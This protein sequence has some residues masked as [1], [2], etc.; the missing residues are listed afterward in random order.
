MTT[1]AVHEFTVELVVRRRLPA[2]DGVVTL[3]LV[4]PA[5]NELPAWEPGAHIDLLLG[6]GLV[7]QYSLCGDPRVPD[8]W[9]I[10]VLLD[11]NSRGG[12]LHVHQRLHEGTPIQVRGPR[13]HFPLVASKRYLFIAGGIGITP[14]KAM[15]ESVERAGFEWA[16]FYLGRSR[17]TMAF[18]QELADTY[19]DRVT[20]WADDERGGFFDVAHALADASEDTLIYSCGPEPLL[21]VVESASAHWP[22]GSLHIERFGAKAPSAQTAAEA[23]DRYEVVCRRSGVTVEV[24]GGVPMLDA[25]E[26]AGISIMSSCGEGVCGTCRATVL[27]GTPAHR[28]SLLTE[29]ERARGDVVLPCVSHSR[30]ETLVLDL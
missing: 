8:T 12:S 4:D 25:L 17:S 19:G 2:A 22:E 21:S 24:A 29:D 5:G 15:A 18:Q 16:M 14:M 3:E 20:V 7:R 23:L 1:S 10:G 11:P 27:E 13:N 30:S 6:D 9:R 28:D 26:D